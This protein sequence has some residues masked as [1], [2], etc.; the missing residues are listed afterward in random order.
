MRSTSNGNRR[1]KNS[2]R[3]LNPPEASFLRVGYATTAMASASIL[4]HPNYNDPT[5]NISQAGNVGVIS[6]VGSSSN[7][8][9]ASTPLDPSGPRAFRTG[10][11]IEF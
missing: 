4:N 9:G 6:G 10:L 3:E 1:L 11:R 8:S 7:V 2:A 5:L